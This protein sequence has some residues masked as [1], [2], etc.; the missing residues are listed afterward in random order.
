M[1][2]AVFEDIR[3]I[4]PRQGWVPPSLVSAWLTDTLNRRYGAVELAPQRRHDSA[5]RQHLREAG[6]VHATVPRDDVV[7]RLDE[8]RLHSF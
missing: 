2:L 7:P 5:S 3:D 4:S 6:R 1:N 8:P